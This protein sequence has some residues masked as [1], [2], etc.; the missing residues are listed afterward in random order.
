MRNVFILFFVLCFFVPAFSQN[1]KDYTNAI[2]LK[3]LN[4]D[5]SYSELKKKIITEFSHSA[6]GRWGEFVTGVDE[7]I[8]TK[9]KVIAF[10][11]DACGGKNGNGYDK[12]LIEYLN[13]EKIPATLFVSGKWIDAQFSVFLNLSHDTLFE[14]ENHGLNHR[15]CSIDGES[16]Y[17]IKGTSGVEEAYDEI[18]AN[19]CKIEAITKH[20][21]R[22]YRSATSFINEA[23]ATMAAKLG[24]T[25]VSYQVLSGDASTLTPV[26]VIEENVLNK[27]KPGDI[28]IMHFNHPEGNTKEAMQKIVPK[29][30]KLGYNFVRL[31]DFELASHKSIMRK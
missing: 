5:L 24:I 23:C 19:A 26:S 22:Y 4:K 18:E 3:K 7:V 20:R 12:E 1:A 10:T 11:F 14:I 21:P 6:P 17:G 13:N 31:D 25:P 27:I 28:V 29:L 2:F 9:Q 15:P 8:L 30:R 16:A